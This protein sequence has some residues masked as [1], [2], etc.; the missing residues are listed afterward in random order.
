MALLDRVACDAAHLDARGTFH[1]GF[2]QKQA[3]ALRASGRRVAWLDLEAG[4]RIAHMK[5]PRDAEFMVIRAPFD[6]TGVTRIDCEIEVP[7]IGVI[8][9]MRDTVFDPADEAL[10]ACC[11]AALAIQA[12]RSPSIWH[13]YSIEGNT[14]HELAAFELRHDVVG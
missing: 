5:F 7:G 8:K 9:T 10:F 4:E 12:S 3:D 14:R 6:L 2:T 13:C 1:P 11:E